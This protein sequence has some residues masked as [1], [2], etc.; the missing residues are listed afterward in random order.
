MPLRTSQA[1]IP[2]GGS[3]PHT[4]FQ[5]YLVVSHIISL[6]GVFPSQS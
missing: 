4:N 2:T 5:P 3:Q 6:F 1:I